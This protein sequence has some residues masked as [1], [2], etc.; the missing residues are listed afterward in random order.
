[1]T[2]SRAPRGAEDRKP[3]SSQSHATSRHPQPTAG[4]WQGQ[5]LL[6]GLKG[7]QAGSP[8]VPRQLAALVVGVGPR[9]GLVPRPV[10]N[11]SEDPPSLQGHLHRWLKALLRPHHNLLSWVLFP[12]LLHT[13]G[14]QGRPDDVS[15]LCTSVAMPPGTQP[16]TMGQVAFWFGSLGRFLACFSPSKVSCPPVP[17]MQAYSVQKRVNVP[18]ALRTLWR[19]SI[20]RAIWAAAES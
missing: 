12:L 11:T 10:G 1:M 15:F 16:R 9:K 6:W 3:S 2:L 19:P 4:L 7:P 18:L 17:P 13:R 14:A 8:S 20:G 5:Q